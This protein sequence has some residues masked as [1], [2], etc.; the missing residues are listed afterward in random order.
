MD[1]ATVFKRSIYLLTAFVGM[2]LGAAE[3]GWIPF[4]SLPV[5][6]LGY[7][8]CEIGL[9]QSRKQARGLGETMSV[10]LGGLSLAAA[11]LEFFGN[12]P[13]GKL[14]SG[15]HLVVYLTWIV[16][17]QRK[18]NSRYWQLLVLGVLQVAV[19]SVLTNGHW[20]GLSVIGYLI[21]ATWT[22]SVFS[23]YRAAE[24]FAGNERRDAGSGARIVTG[25]DADPARATSQAISAVCH[26]DGSGGVTPRFVGGVAFTAMLGL[27]VGSLFFV[28][29]PRIWIGTSFGLAENELPPTLRS[30]ITGLATEVRLG[31]MRQVLESNDPVLSLRLFDHQT[32]QPLDPDTYA[33][34]LGHPEPLF[35]GVIL[36]DYKEGRWRPHRLAT[37]QTVQLFPV[38]DDPRILFATSGVVI[39]T[40][41]QE[42]HLDQNLHDILF[43]M[44]RAVAMTDDMRETE[45]YRVGRR[46]LLNDV[47][48]R[49]EWF[50]ELS[51]G[52]DYIA[53]SE[54]PPP[55]ARHEVGYVASKLASA[56]Y[57]YTNYFARCRDVPDGLERLS[58]LAF[59][60]VETEQ[61]RVGR[62][63]TVLEQA[64]AIESHLRDS[65]RFAYS[66]SAPT[67][68]PWIEP[69]EDFLFNSRKGH[70]QYFASAL[71]L[72]LRSVGIP[73]RLVTG[74]KEPIRPDRRCGH[75]P[76]LS[77]R[78]R[79]GQPSTGNEGLQLLRA[80][81]RRQTRDARRD[82]AVVH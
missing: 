65:G 63:L 52:V 48:V 46:Q 34:W 76:H 82:P 1:L 73:A 81:D 47:V 29:I 50:K 60:V 64:R 78:R 58:G 33:E 5:T 14:L 70:C 62:F 25:V 68:D 77:N 67:S 45:R 27:I 21:A 2:V 18:K 28:F 55:D 66:L 43:C 53:Y 11:T 23:L 38:P 72:M 24:E 17:L 49:R 75:S 13:E 42:I 35:R 57:G 54:L 16:L 12:N 22:M 31:D 10:V 59:E 8:W 51:G 44:G 15:I 80:R 36:T 20:F 71:G 26:D 7:W 37:E 69:V 41:R 32:N 39:P 6:I 30:T 4:V 61:Q 40:V 79:Q 19:A 9:G 74:F 56:T 3:W